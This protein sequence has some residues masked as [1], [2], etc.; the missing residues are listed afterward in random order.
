MEIANLQQRVRENFYLS[1]TRIAGV[2]EGREPYEC[3]VKN[4]CSEIEIEG[5]LALHHRLSIGPDHVLVCKTPL[6][7]EVLNGINGLLYSQAGNLTNQGIEELK[8]MAGLTATTYILIYQTSQRTSIVMSYS[9][10]TRAHKNL[11]KVAGF[12]SYEAVSVHPVERKKE[13]DDV[14][15]ALIDSVASKPFF[16]VAKEVKKRKGILEKR[17]G[18]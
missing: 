6:P 2:M 4:A 13:D 12:K 10:A 7:A 3:K 8:A 9:P 18:D 1:G 15:R 5:D 14:L 16:S 11:E 17:L